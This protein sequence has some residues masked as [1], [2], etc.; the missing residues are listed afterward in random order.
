MIENVELRHFKCFE[1]LNLPLARLTLLTGLNASGKSTVLQS[2]ALLHQTMIDHEWSNELLLS[3]SKISLGAVADVIDEVTGRDQ[4]QIGVRGNGSDCYWTARASDRLALSIP[5]R[6]I[7]TMDRVVAIS[8][9]SDQPLLRLLPSSLK[10]N[11]G[12]NALIEALHE[13]VYISAERSGPREVYAL[14]ASS[15]L[16]DVGCRGERTPG[17]LHQCGDLRPEDA[18]I[19]AGVA[20]TL[21]RQVEGWMDR[22]FPGSSIEILPVAG[23]N[24]VTLGIRT[25]ESSGYK[26]PQNVG[27]GLTHIM[28]ILAAC[29]AARRDSLILI[30]N[31][32]AHLHPVGQADMGRF[33]SRA[34]AAGVQIIAETHS[35]HVLNGVRRSVKEGILSPDEVAIY[36]FTP[37]NEEGNSSVATHAQVAS[38]AVDSGGGLD[39]WPAGFFDQIDKDSSFLAGWGE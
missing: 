14:T 25:S 7:R 29:L 36:F 11:P 9:S 18:L 10:A 32:E 37:R 2:L 21:K 35:D 4:F 13:T 26:R 34:A 6:E 15:H 24:L 17:V 1:T 38:V 16:T 30:E 28:P 27:Y 39:S 33:L 22:F 31:P 23:A 8:A 12:L 19:L 5:I 20:P 3:G